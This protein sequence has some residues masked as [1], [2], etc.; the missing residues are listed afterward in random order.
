[1]I[2]LILKPY[3]SKEIQGFPKLMKLL[4]V[5]V[6]LGKKKSRIVV[7]FYVIDLLL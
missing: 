1:M 7:F 2:M 5:K 6:R 4:N 3:H